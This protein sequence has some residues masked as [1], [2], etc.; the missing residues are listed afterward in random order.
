MTGGDSNGSNMDMST[1]FEKA[2]RKCPVVTVQFSRVDVPCLIDSGSEVSPI[3]E[4]FFNDH[5]C[6]QGKPVLPTGDWLRLI[7]ANGLP[8]PYTGYLELDVEASRVMIP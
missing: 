4:E 3:T 2:V 7:A 5:F 6:P 1:V 8:I